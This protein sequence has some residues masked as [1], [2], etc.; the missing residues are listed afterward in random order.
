M[1]FYKKNEKTF[2]F[3]LFLIFLIAFLPYARRSLPQKKDESFL[4]L[5]YCSVSVWI[6]MISS[7]QLIIRQSAFQLLLRYAFLITKQKALIQQY[8]SVP[9]YMIFKKIL[10]Y[11]YLH[12]IMHKKGSNSGTPLHS[13]TFCVGYRVQIVQPQK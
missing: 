4:I 11:V 10:K 8:F 6:T 1:H 2:A 13:K 12:I 5:A 3:L 9:S 7:P